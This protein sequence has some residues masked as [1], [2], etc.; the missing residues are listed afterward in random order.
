M[1][2]S[3]FR[4]GIFKNTEHFKV[5]RTVMGFITNTPHSA[6]GTRARVSGYEAS[7][8]QALSLPS[9]TP[10]LTLTQQFAQAHRA[11]PF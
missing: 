8:G 4:V 2:Y 9:I 10:F 6:P 5:T 3:L 1:L 11:L 7:T